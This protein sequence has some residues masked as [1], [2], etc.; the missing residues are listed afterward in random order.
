MRGQLPLHFILQHCPPSTRCLTLS[1]GGWARVDTEHD[2]F[3][4]D[5]TQVNTN[6]TYPFSAKYKAESGDPGFPTASADKWLPA[7][8]GVYRPDNIGEYDS[9]PAVIN[10]NAYNLVI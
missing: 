7:G 3:K 4:I 5:L 2:D 1:Y 6:V 8:S 10:P 9:T